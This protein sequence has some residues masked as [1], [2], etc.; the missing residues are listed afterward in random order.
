MVIF[1]CKDDFDSILCG[2][3]DAW[4][5]R[6]GHDNVRLQLQGAYNMELFAKYRDV[7]VTEE[8]V[9]KVIQAVVQKISREAYG[10]IYRA[11]LSYEPEKADIIY[12]FLIFGFHIG[13]QITES[14]HIPAVHEIFRINRHIQNEAHNILPMLAL[15]FSDR[16]RP[17][18]F[19][20]YDEIREKAVIY[21]PNT[22]WYILSGEEGKRLEKLS[23]KS[24]RKEY[25][26]LWKIFFDSVAIKERENYVCQRGH[27]A[28][29]Y[30][31]Y[32]TE[33]Q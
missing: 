31:P 18:R 16:L 32:M 3:Y 11:S 27:L 30:R 20:I 14:L 25:E 33:F 26:T 6:L 8:K 4:M 13:K 9:D 17:E 29:R 15:H 24:D 10:W 2:V 1:I 5:S 19:I 21:T 23:E 7:Q 22:G 28:L 12:R